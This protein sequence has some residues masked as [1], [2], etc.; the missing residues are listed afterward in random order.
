MIILLGRPM[1]M[2][3]HHVA[4]VVMV[5]VTA[6]SRL[7]DNGMIVAVI[8]GAEEARATETQGAPRTVQLTGAEGI[9]EARARI[10]IVVETAIGMIIAALDAVLNVTTIVSVAIEKQIS[11]ILAP[12]RMP[13]AP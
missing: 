9:N 11:L 6:L 8:S 5:S 1:A 7:M 10:E 12:A 3:S 4:H 2:V 13:L